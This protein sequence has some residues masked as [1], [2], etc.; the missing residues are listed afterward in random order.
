MTIYPFL[1]SSF[2]HAHVAR[3]TIRT[4]D[5]ECHVTLIELRPLVFGE[6]KLVS[7][8]ICGC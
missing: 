2:R 7:E 1:Q 4:I 8:G 3:L 5:W 6:H